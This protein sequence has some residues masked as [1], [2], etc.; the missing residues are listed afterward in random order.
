MFIWAENF[1]EHFLF[2]DQNYVLLP[3]TENLLV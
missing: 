2:Q 3:F 1:R